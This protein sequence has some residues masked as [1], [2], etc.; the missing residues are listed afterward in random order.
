MTN[1]DLQKDV[2]V[3]LG[4]QWVLYSDPN[5]A[6][7]YSFTAVL[8]NRLRDA[9]KADTSLTQLARSVTGFISDSTAGAGISITVRETTFGG[10][11]IHFLGTPLLRPSWAVHD[12]ILYVGMFPQV[13]AA[14][15]SHPALAGKTILDNPQFV[16]LFQRLGQH[17]PTSLAYIDLP[18]TRH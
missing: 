4:D 1:L 17:E 9:A 15:A 3:P 16:A 18:R 6:G 12:G 14:A 10:V 11:T 13:V 5:M 7:S 2:L 8:M